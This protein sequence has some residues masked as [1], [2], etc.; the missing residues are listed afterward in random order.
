[1]GDN[2]ELAGPGGRAFSLPKTDLDFGPVTELGDDAF[3]EGEWTL[4]AAGGDDL[5][6]F[7]SPF[8]VR[9]L[10]NLNLPASVPLGGALE[11][12]WDGSAYQEGD[13]ITISLTQNPAE[14]PQAGLK[15]VRCSVD[16]TRGSVEMT[17]QNLASLEAAPG[18]PLLWEIEVETAPQAINAEDLDYG[19]LTTLISTTE[20]ATA[21]E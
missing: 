8:S 17:V 7:S 2:V 11:I 12:A 4:S 15:T 10:P 21:A 19:R 20:E 3:V 16:A 14:P 5:G 6:A 9:G 18:S 13:R 1:M